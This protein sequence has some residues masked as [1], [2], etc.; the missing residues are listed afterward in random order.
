MLLLPFIT[1]QAKLFVKTAVDIDRRIR[2][3]TFSCHLSIISKAKKRLA[4]ILKEI[5]GV[6][7]I[8]MFDQS[9]DVAR[10][11]NESFEVCH[12]ANYNK[13]IILIILIDDYIQ[14]IHIYTHT[15][16]YIYRKSRLHFLLKN[17]LKF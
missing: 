4:P 11:A 15:H 13:K 9:K 6:W 7:F 1:F 2:Y 16:I 3:S 5:I 12:I 10:I 8:S 17:V 14:Q